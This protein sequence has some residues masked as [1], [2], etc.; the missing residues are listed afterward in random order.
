MAVGSSGPPLMVAMLRGK[1]AGK[2][3]PVPDVY[4]TSW[5]GCSMGAVQTC[6]W[7]AELTAI[8]AELPKSHRNGWGRAKPT[9][10]W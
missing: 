9:P 5:Q 1:A 6:A 4:V 3:T 7:M 8:G 10:M 2:R